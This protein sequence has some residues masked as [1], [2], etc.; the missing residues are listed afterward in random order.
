MWR[1]GDVLGFRVTRLAFGSQSELVHGFTRT[2]T[3]REDNAMLCTL[4]D[5][6]AMLR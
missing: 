5:P 6:L 4:T 3:R 1:N 2:E